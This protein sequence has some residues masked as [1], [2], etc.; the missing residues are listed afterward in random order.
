MVYIFKHGKFQSII[1]TRNKIQPSYLFPDF[2]W[3]CISELTLHGS[4]GWFFHLTLICWLP[5]LS[6][7]GNN[8][9]VSHPLRIHTPYH[10]CRFLLIFHKLS[11]KNK[12]LNNKGWIEYM[13]LWLISGAGD[14][15]WLKKNI[16]HV[17]VM[18][19][20][21]SEIIR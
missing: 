17:S 14:L 2:S 11:S 5:F 6:G 3:N 16:L 10:S 8:I 13:L 9:Q 18:S 20:I 12:P 15:L 7:V 19:N 4:L 1:L 21:S